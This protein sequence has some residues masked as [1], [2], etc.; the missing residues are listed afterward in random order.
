MSEAIPI[1]SFARALPFW[2][3]LSLLGVVFVAG[4]FGGLA[5]LAV[6]IYAFGV[7]SLLD[8]ALGI[9]HRNADTETNESLLWYKLI[10]WIWLPLQVIAVFGALWVVCRTDHLPGREGLYLMLALGVVS[11]AIGIVYA[12][13][14]MHQKN[15]FE[16]KLGEWLMISVL[17]GHFVT[18]HL[19]VHHTH[20]AT[21]KD[22]ATARYNESLY[23]FFVR[24]LWGSLISAWRVDAERTKRKTGSSFGFA[25]PFWRY[26]GGGFLFLL[27][28]FWIGGWTGVGLYLA[29]ALVAI[30]QL[31]QINYIE[32]YGLLRRKKDNGKY[33]PVAPRHSWNAAHKATNYLLINLQRHSD[34]HY[35]PDRR[36][37]LLQN[38]EETEAPQLP[39]GYPI[40]V[41]LSF[42]PW[43][44]RRVMNK[45]VRR[46]RSMYYPDILDW[47]FAR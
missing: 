20:V 43:A 5:L 35:K 23:R 32:H 1:S 8:A 13:E 38:Y 17:Y 44:W 7:M 37:P 29:H 25:N 46:W 27:V 12:H 30:L 33:E 24:V 3:S 45:R 40:M 15:K 26:I 6:P 9:E 28:A 21:P 11:G 14:L 2:L 39:F 36:Y 22:V 41:L 31:E 18:E 16:R 42:N 10:T 47:S 4:W 34:H 19:H